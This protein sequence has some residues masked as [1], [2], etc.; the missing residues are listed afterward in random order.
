M[1]AAM[2][3]AALVGLGGFFGSLARY[4]LTLVVQRQFPGS[5]FPW[6][7]LAVNLLGC[8]LIGIIAGIAQER[9]VL[10]PGIS[11]FLLIGVLGGF[12]TFSTFGY[13]TFALLREAAFLQAAATVLLHIVAGVALVWLGFVLSTGKLA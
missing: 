8:F 3:Y 6:G 2:T 5:L 1:K 7:T 10:S 13:E 4:G 11:V 9:Q 12:T